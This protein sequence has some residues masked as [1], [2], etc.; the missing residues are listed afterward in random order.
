VPILSPGSVCFRRVPKLIR[1]LGIGLLAAALSAVPGATGAARGA[2]LGPHC[3]WLEESLPVQT[4]VSELTSAMTLEQKISLMQLQK[5][6]G[7]YAGY[8]HYVPPIPQLCVPAIVQQDDSAGVAGGV[9]GVTQ[10]PAPI[11]AASTFSTS[12]MY[13]YGATIGSEMRGEGVDDALAPT[14]NLLRVPEWGRAFE[15]LGE[16]PFLTSQLG[17]ADIEGIQSQGVIA[18]VKHFIDY[19]QETGRNPGAPGPLDDDIISAR[20]MR[21]TE[22]SVFESAIED[23][24]VGGIM[25]AFPLIN[26]I[27]TCQDPYLLTT[28]LRNQFGFQGYIR[29]DNPAPLT[30]DVEAVNAGLDQAVVPH[31]D[32]T[33]L[34]ADV[35]NG[36][37]SPATIDAAASAILYPMFQLGIFNDP[38]TGTVDTNVSTPAD[39]AFALQAAEQ[40]TVLLRNQDSL[41][42]LRAGHLR[43]ITVYG[44][45]ASDSPVTAGGGSGHV[46]ASS[47]ITPLEAIQAR[48]GSGVSVSYSP[49]GGPPSPAQTKRRR[50]GRHR[51]VRDA[52]VS[53]VAIVFVGK[54]EGEG[55]DEQNLRLPAAEERLIGAVA[56]A[57]KHTIVV[58]NS[59]GPVVMPWIAHVQ[60][61]IE[62]WFPGQQDGA[63]IA[64]ILFGD[65]NPSGKL[66]VTFP[67]TGSQSL[68]GARS[69]WPGIHGEVHYSEGLD[70]GYRWYDAH[71][72]TPLFPFGFGLS[73]TTFSFSRLRIT[74]VKTRGLDPNGQPGQVVAY[75]HARLANTGGRLGADVAQLYLGD[76]PSAG[77]PVRQLRG[78]ARLQLAPHQ[79]AS[80]TLPLTAREL[81]YWN[82]YANRWMIARGRYA[83]YVGDS[84]ALS[85]LPLRGALSVG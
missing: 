62:G 17:D 20:T 43:S 10:L 9:T 7:A 12:T 68:A 65:V 14:L 69:R 4:R 81:A 24:H 29:S 72:Y 74:P 2:L 26:G 49:T 15:S 85:G 22:L 61:V 45:D 50:P 55:F 56:R 54:P 70:I 33:Q 80:V 1:A 40:G 34:L 78:F 60:A 8:E 3:P 32:P 57:N 51:R 42:P 63:A 73:Y 76:P 59:G 18:D 28:V 64:A 19:N 75:V 11:A 82:S 38:P 71:H 79:R 16:D 31:L 67:L 39:Q 5:G 77:E 25:C 58:L 84:S 30:S 48:V 44:T 53:H 6:S 66:P 46:T 41:L 27:F 83:V 13:S 37:I 21:E 23:A 47:I 52:N 36:S 35:Q